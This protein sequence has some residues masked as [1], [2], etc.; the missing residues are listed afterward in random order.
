MKDSTAK[1]CTCPGQSGNN[2]V[3]A[4][5]MLVRQEVRFEAFLVVFKEHLDKFKYLVVSISFPIF[6]CI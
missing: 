2:P 1:A 3:D 4:A 6:C 5:M